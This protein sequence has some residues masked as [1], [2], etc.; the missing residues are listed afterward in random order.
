M[1]QSKDYNQPHKINAH[2][3]ILACTQQL[4]TKLV[5][6]GLWVD[7]ISAQLWIFKSTTTKLMKKA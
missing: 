2:F 6:I 4:Q 3:A 5:N 7:T 1:T